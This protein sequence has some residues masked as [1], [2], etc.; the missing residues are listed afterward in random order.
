MAIYY[1]DSIS[2]LDGNPG[3]SGLPKQTIAA[4]I[5]LCT[6]KGDRLRLRNTGP[7]TW[8]VGTVG[9]SLPAGTIGTSFSDFGTLIEGVD[10]MDNP[11]TTTIAATGADGSRSICRVNDNTGYLIW[12]NIAFDATTK[13]ADGN[14]YEICEHNDAGSPDPGPIR[15][16][17]CSFIYGATGVRPTGARSEIVVTAG[18]GALG[19]DAAEFDR[20]YFQNHPANVLSSQFGGRKVKFDECVFIVDSAALGAQIFDLGSFESASGLLRFKNCTV[21][22]NIGAF[23][24]NNIIGY[25]AGSGTNVGV[26]DVYNNVFFLEST[27][28][29]QFILLDGVGGVATVTKTGTINYNVVLGGPNITAVDIGANGPYNDPWGLPQA[30][31]ANDTVA[32]SQVESAIFFA[33]SSAYTWDMLGNGATVSILK[34]L[35]LIAHQTA[36]LAGAR[37]G[38]LPLP[39]S[40][41]SVDLAASRLNPTIDEDVTLTFTL[42][43]TGNLGHN[44]IA[45]LLIPTGLTITSAIASQGSY[46]AGTGIWTVG[47]LAT[48][49]PVTLTIT[50]SVNNDQGGNSFILTANYVSSDLTDSNA[51]NNSE[52][53]TIAVQDDDSPIDGPGA[54]PFIDV[55]PFFADVLQIDCFARLYTRIN[56]VVNANVRYDRRRDQF[57]EFSSKRYTIPALT[58]L[59]INMG[60]LQ[61]ARFLTIEAIE[62]SVLVSISPN[63]DDDFYSPALEFLYVGQTDF[64]VLKIQNPSTTSVDVLLSVVD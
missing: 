28:G 53:V 35:R 17:G 57:V 7:I 55:L 26:V 16:E 15:F 40:D 18:P 31:Q 51:L 52:S 32:Y 44:V 23:S 9:T 39:V 46:V 63:V 42:L 61:R 48:A 54:V 5:A 49:T 2:G 30:Y 3:T 25:D 6:V 60:G 59:T 45:S 56:R 62:S 58:T 27:V 24:M 11:A 36:G 50:V 43:N 20:C 19:S 10:A 21:Y 22:W 33:P 38:A 34:D 41:F 4:G 8:T 37:P 47:S 14:S 1:V 64:E 13:T 12:R 29:A